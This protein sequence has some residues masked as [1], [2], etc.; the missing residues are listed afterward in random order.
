MVALKLG[1]LPMLE[2]SKSDSDVNYLLSG[3]LVGHYVHPLAGL[4][5]KEMPWNVEFTFAWGFGHALEATF[6][7]VWQS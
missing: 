3:Y 5:L 6:D 1:Y 4:S 2:P 7:F